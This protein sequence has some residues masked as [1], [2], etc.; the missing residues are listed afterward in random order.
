[1]P[2]PGPQPFVPWTFL[3]PTAG[4]PY[5]VYRRK[6]SPPFGAT[7]V[8]MMNTADAHP[9]VM[10]AITALGMAFGGTAGLRFGP[11]A[12]TGAHA[13]SVI[14][15]AT[16]GFLVAP[17]VGDAVGTG[18]L[19]AAWNNAVTRHWYDEA[20]RGATLTLLGGI[21]AGY[22]AGNSFDR[23]LDDASRKNGKPRRKRKG[24]K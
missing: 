12:T 15:G 20:G 3:P 19:S 18:S 1:M 23:L 14:A 6:G 16:L 9:N 7:P 5:L 2:F 13:A 4:A 10:M 8:D 24:R 17:F 22:V 21:G 11:K